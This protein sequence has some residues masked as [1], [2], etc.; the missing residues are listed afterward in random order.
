MANWKNHLVISARSLALGAKKS[1]MHARLPIA[2][3]N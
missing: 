1:L 3:P 2:V